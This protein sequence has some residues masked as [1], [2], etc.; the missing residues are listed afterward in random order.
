MWDREHPDKN[1]Y[2]PSILPT[3][4]DEC[5]IC[6]RGGDL[7][8]HEIYF[9]N[10]NRQHSKAHGTWVYLC[11]ACHKRVH[12]DPSSGFDGYLK[13]KGQRWFTFSRTIEEFIEIFGRRYDSD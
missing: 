9:G 2:I 11:P 13:E 1:G 5:Y 8:R 6:K 12:E 4:E 10:P 3:N 7:V